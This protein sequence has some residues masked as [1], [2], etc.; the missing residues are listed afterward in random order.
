M[1]SYRITIKYEPFDISNHDDIV[2]NM[3]FKSIAKF[4]N[5][6]HAHAPFRNLICKDTYSF[7]SNLEIFLGYCHPI[8]NGKEIEL[9]ITCNISP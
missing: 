5:T 6:K 8:H 9:L 4:V 3:H 2:L 7:T 1:K